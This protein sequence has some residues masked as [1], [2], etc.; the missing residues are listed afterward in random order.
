MHQR[1]S[2]LARRILIACG[3][4][5][6]LV[7]LCWALRLPACRHAYSS[8]G[9]YESVHDLLKEYQATVRMVQVK[10]NV[11]FLAGTVERFQSRDLVGMEDWMCVVQKKYGRPGAAGIEQPGSLQPESTAH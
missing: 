3:L 9:T 10:G 5:L 7:Y 1:H 6:G 8:Q 11:F 2:G 4:L